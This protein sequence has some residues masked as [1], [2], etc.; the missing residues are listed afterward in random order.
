M[1]LFSSFSGF[2]MTTYIRLVNNVPHFIFAHFWR[3]FVVSICSSFFTY[4][5][6]CFALSSD[7]L[8]LSSIVCIL[9][10]NPFNEFPTSNTV[11]CYFQNIHF[12]LFYRSQFSIEIV[13]HS[14]YIFFSFISYIIQF[15]EALACQLW[16]FS[17]SV[18]IDYFIY[19]WTLFLLLVMYGNFLIA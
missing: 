12:I 1:H 11:F 8:I 18:C 7:L 13:L 14:F 5:D 19:Y 2:P 16:I 17:K 4:I 10:L 3:D 9:Q 6:L 15:F